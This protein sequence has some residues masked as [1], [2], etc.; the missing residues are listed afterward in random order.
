M[1]DGLSDTRPRAPATVIERLAR[2]A[3]RMRAVRDRL[4]LTPWRTFVVAYQ[5]TGGARGRGKPGLTKE[6]ELTP[7]PALTSAAGLKVSPTSGGLVADGVVRLTEISPRYTEDDLDL[8]FQPSGAEGD[9]ATIVIGPI[10]ALQTS[11]GD[12]FFAPMAGLYVE[13]TDGA[14]KGRIARIT[15]RLGPTEVSLEGDGLV[16]EIATASWVLREWADLGFV[17]SQP[18]N[19]S[20]AVDDALDELA[21]EVDRRRQ[22]G[23]SDDELR[24]ALLTIQDT[25]SIGAIIRAC[26][27]ALGRY[28]TILVYETG[29]PAFEAEPTIGL[30]ACPG[31]V[32]GLSPCGVSPDALAA[33]AAGAPVS[34]PAGLTA[35]MPLYRFFVL[36]WDGA[37]LGDP[38]AYVRDSSGVVD[39]DPVPMAAAAGVSPAG[40]YATGDAALRAGISATINQIKAGGVGWRWYPRRFWD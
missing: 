15:A 38:G 37:G 23:E 12:H 16:A 11:G 5:W 7:R 40:G 8:L 39:V 36:R 19:A 25:V 13:F 26:N 3:D 31:V 24:T 4:G 32:A 27:R 21:D 20:Q 33:P 18:D 29:T 1:T 28:G 9:E 14:N 6:I 30:E 22:A 10:A 17:V 34:P 35:V 2:V